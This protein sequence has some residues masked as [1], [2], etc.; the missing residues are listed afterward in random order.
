MGVGCW[1]GGAGHF[2]ENCLWPCRF[3]EME[4]TRI[5]FF[6]DEEVSG[7]WAAVIGCC[8]YGGCHHTSNLQ[9]E[10]VETY[11][12]QSPCANNGVY[13][14]QEI[15]TRQASRSNHTALRS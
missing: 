10:T 1:S 5:K 11:G 2:L 7:A 4:G 6:E 13:N 12:K 14:R 15:V 3:L 9:S 8:G